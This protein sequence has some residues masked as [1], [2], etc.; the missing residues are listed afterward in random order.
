MSS[1]LNAAI[2]VQ[3]RMGSV[4]LPGKALAE[5][6]GEPLLG[7]VAARLGSAPVCGP[8]IVAIP[9]GAGDD[10]I[11]LWCR[12]QGLRCFRGSEEDVLDRFWRAVADEK[13]DYVVRATGDNPLVWEGAVAFMAERMVPEG[14]DYCAF[15]GR[16]TLGLGL[17]LFT[18]DALDRAR[19]AARHAYQREHV[20]PW[21]YEDKRR[22]R[23]AHFDPPAALRSP[24]RLTV[25]TPEDLELMRLL[26]DRLYRPG[27]IVP[28][29]EAVKHLRDNPDA[30]GINAA[31]RQKGYKESGQRPRP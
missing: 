7:H 26:Y 27:R 18:R 3:A 17:E 28:A 23:A 21:M 13:V 16:V 10:Q 14:L 15:T 22:F 6:A 20:T 19:R 5:L 9:D 31:V 12:R 24:Y 11:E 25:D 29:A 1:E 30:A 4:R 2:V 8:L